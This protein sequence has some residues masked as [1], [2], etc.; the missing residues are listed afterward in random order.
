M[1]TNIK[2]KILTIYVFSLVLFATFIIIFSTLYHKKYVERRMLTIAEEVKVNDTVYNAIVGLRNRGFDVVIYDSHNPLLNIHLE[3]IKRNDATINYTEIKSTTTKSLKLLVNNHYLIEITGST[4][5][6]YMSSLYLIIISVVVLYLI[7]SFVIIQYLLFGFVNPLVKI[8]EELLRISKFDFDFNSLNVDRSDEIGDLARNVENIKF[9]LKSYHK[10]RSV[11]VSALVHELKSPV[12]TISAVLQLNQMGHKDYNT[13]YMREIIEE[14]IQTISSI[15]KLSLEVFEKKGIYKFVQCDACKIVEECFLQVQP[16][17]VSKNLV[18]KRECEKSIW[19]IDEE[20]FEIVIS[21][22]VAN[23][24]NY[25]ADNSD[26]KIVVKD[27]TIS[28]SNEINNKFSSGTGKGLKIISS[29]L[30]DMDIDFEY[31][32]K[33]NIYHVIIKKMH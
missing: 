28:F 13:E 3:S 14:N 24:C 6:E 22:I 30:S 5:K 9:S 8:N 16:V 4:L 11:L 19:R 12:A 26:V 17:L 32:E 23:I 1:K 15:I 2:I 7:I 18:I 21:N 33:N 27:D 29:L 20:S 10:N 25:S 31:Y